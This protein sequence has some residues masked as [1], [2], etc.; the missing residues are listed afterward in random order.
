MVNRRQKEEQHSHR[1]NKSP[2]C[3][4]CANKKEH[5]KEKGINKVT[6]RKKE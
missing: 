6:G 2:Y 4:R 5:S 1:R 3:I